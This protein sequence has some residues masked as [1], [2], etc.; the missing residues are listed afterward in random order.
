MLWVIFL[1]NDKEPLMFINTCNSINNV[2]WQEKFD[3]RNH[4]KRL[5]EEV[6]G[7]LTEK[8]IKKLKSMIEL[9][10]RN[11]MVYCKIVLVDRDV[12]GVPV[13]LKNGVL[14]IKNSDSNLSDIQISKIK[15]IEILHF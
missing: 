9:Y 4:S 11:Q 3:S 6:I 1:I 15:G 8:E 10:N 5:V 7:T 2:S 13:M 14:T 12:L